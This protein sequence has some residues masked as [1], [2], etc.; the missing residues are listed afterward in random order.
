[1]AAAAEVACGE[2]LDADRCTYHGRV[3]R[4]GGY[5]VLQ[6]WFFY[7]FN[8]WRSTFSGINDHEADWELV[9]V[10]LADDGGERP[11]PRWVAASCHDHSG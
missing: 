10:Y 7:V 1:M 11:A 8:D 4:D 9:T 6:Y 3:L 2:H 5:L